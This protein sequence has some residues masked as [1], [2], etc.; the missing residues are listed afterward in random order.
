MHETVLMKLILEKSIDLYMIVKD[1]AWKRNMSEFM[2]EKW[3][4]IKYI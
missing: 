4:N 1:Q 3:V 2:S